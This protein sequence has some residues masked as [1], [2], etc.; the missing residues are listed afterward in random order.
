VEARRDPEQAAARARQH[1]LAAKRVERLV[2]EPRGRDREPVGGGEGA[3]T[4]PS[5]K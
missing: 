1:D 2:A 3:T 4:P 5:R